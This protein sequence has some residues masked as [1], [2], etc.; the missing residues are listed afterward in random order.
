MPGLKQ[1]RYA[2][3]PYAI[4]T[5]T[6]KD[7][8]KMGIT[9]GPALGY[10]EFS[11]YDGEGKPSQDTKDTPTMTRYHETADEAPMNE[12]ASVCTDDSHSIITGVDAGIDEAGNRY[13]CI[14]YDNWATII[15]W[16]KRDPH[17]YDKCI[18]HG[19]SHTVIISPTQRAVDN[20]IFE[21]YT[22]ADNDSC[23]D[24]QSYIM[25]SAW[26]KK[27]ARFP[28]IQDIML[29]K[30][31]YSASLIRAKLVGADEHTKREVYYAGADAL[32]R[33]QK[34][35]SCVLACFP[36]ILQDAIGYKDLSINK[37]ANYT[38]DKRSNDRICDKLWLFSYYELNADKIVYADNSISEYQGVNY[39]KNRASKDWWWL[40]SPYGTYIV[41]SVYENGKISSGIVDAQIAIAPGF[42]LSA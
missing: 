23:G 21:D 37:D 42:T 36:E 22:L 4:G 20:G 10:P 25:K 38:W 3:M 27:Y 33:Y 9:F 14:H 34:A 41:W 28:I 40:R 18:E 15:Y 29:P 2:V 17:V 16:N 12:S 11:Q 26:N 24:G 1:I 32:I 30:R 35:D 39:H 31:G 8:K 5:D 7:G 13:R 6:D 19:C